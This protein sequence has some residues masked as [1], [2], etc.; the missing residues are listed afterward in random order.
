M[1]KKNLFLGILAITL[2]FGMTVVGCGDDS[3]DGGGGGGGSGTGTVVLKN[4]FSI[5]LR[6]IKLTNGGSQVGYK[7]TLDNNK[8]NT[9][10]N[11]P[12]GLCTIEF[13][14][15]GKSTSHK[16]TVGS[17]ENVSINYSSNGNFV[18]TRSG[19][20]GGSSSGGTSTTDTG[21]IKIVNNSG[22]DTF[23]G[24][25][26]GPD[27]KAIPSI[28]KGG[29]TTVTGLSVGTYTVQVSSKRGANLYYWKKTGVT[30]TKGSTTTVTLTSSGWGL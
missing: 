10:S 21:S 14:I 8:S 4:S 7:E 15:S 12:T 11:V 23:G 17:G 13:Q 18:I 1:K 27:G 25:I 22:Y 5:E 3:T 20:S 26:T 9:F 29:N 30:V 2:V 24:T 16:F 19:G 6:K 28:T